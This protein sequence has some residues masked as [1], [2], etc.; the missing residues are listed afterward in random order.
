M[1]TVKLYRSLFSL[2]SGLVLMATCYPS[3]AQ[4]QSVWQDRRADLGGWLDTSTGLVWGQDFCSATDSSWDWDGANRHLV[5]LRAITHNASWRLPTVNELLDVSTKGG[6]S[7]L[8]V[9]NGELANSCWSSEVPKKNSKQRAYAV[10]VG[11]SHGGVL[12]YA[13]GSWL[14]A[15]PVYRAFIP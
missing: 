5:D 15:I 2:L 11:D 10:S 6:Y 9:A 13:K 12:D 14:N 4:A 8:I 1:N 3:E 7:L